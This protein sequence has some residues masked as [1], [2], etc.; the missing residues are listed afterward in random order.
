VRQALLPDCPT[1]NRPDRVAGLLRCNH[2]GGAVICCVIRVTPLCKLPLR[3]PA[4]KWCRT[5]DWLLPPR[6]Y[7][8]E[9]E[10]IARQ[11]VRNIGYIDS[12][13]DSMKRG[14][15]CSTTATGFAAIFGGVGCGYVVSD[16]DAIGFIRFR[17]RCGKI[18]RPHVSAG[19]LWRQWTVSSFDPPQIRVIKYQNVDVRYQVGP[20]VSISLR[21][22]FSPSSGWA[23]LPMPPTS[24][25]A[26]A[27]PTLQT[28]PKFSCCSSV[29]VS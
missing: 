8:W 23:D 4:A 22:D 3:P 10:K 13:G 5:C 7:C 11:R 24:A 19:Y 29:F 28:Y 21:P 17:L 15:I 20:Q 1:P 9:V 26:T 27:L 6:G 16:R 12:D 2:A 18:M 25:W 14:P